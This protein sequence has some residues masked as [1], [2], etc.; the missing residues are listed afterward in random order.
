MATKSG[1]IKNIPI[2]LNNALLIISSSTPILLSILNF[3]TLSLDSDNSLR[4]KIA[5]QEIKKV[6][7]K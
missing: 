3:S 7:P 4:A 2:C 5:A 6:I 1:N